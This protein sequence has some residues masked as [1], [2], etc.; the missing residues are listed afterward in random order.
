MARVRARARPDWPLAT[1][2][3]GVLPCWGANGFVAGRPF[4]MVPDRARAHA[5]GLARAGLPAIPRHGQPTAPSEGPQ[6]A[7]VNPLLAHDGAR[8]LLALEDGT[9]FEGLSVGA[10]GEAFGEIVFNTSLSGYQEVISDPSYAGQV[11]CF[12]YPQIGNYGVCAADMQSDGVAL[13][14]VVVGDMCHTPNNWRAEQSLP[15]FLAERGIVAIEGVDTREVTLHVREAGTMRCAISTTDLD[16]ASLVARVKAAPSISEH[17]WVADVS[18]GEPYDVPAK[19]DLDRPRKRLSVVA[20]DCGEKRGILRGLVSVGLDVRVVPWDTAAE[21]ILA[22]GPDG[23]FLSNGPCDPREVHEPAACARELLGKVPVFGICLGHQ[24]MCQ[25]AGAS[26][27][28]LP[29]GHHGGNQ[30]VMNLLSGMVE[31]T[32][33][34]HNYGLEFESLGELVPE[35]SGGQQVVDEWHAAGTHDLRFWSERRI[36]PVVDSRPFG[37]IRLTH[38]NLNDGTPEGIQF[39]EIPAFCVQY[40][41]EAS[42][43]PHDAAYL[44]EAFRRL[45]EGVPDYLAID[46]REGRRF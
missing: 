33:Q 36:A 25:A 28:K 45:I 20:L 4:F 23:V 14:G 39:L 34:N 26:I 24:M 8:A 40:H 15:D 5:P 1:P 16:P 44:F 2:H 12:T 22:L 7:R 35:L 31:V 13:A 38:V 27:E 37:R 21:E 9:T 3:D 32:A 6:G 18:C 17:N 42:P 43:G 10:S 46:V 41:P 30:P 19:V 29:Y 11:V